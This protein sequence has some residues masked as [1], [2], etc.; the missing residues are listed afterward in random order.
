[1][2]PRSM[3][4]PLLLIAPLLVV[5]VAAV[6]LAVFSPEAPPRRA[7]AT[8]YDTG[9]LQGTVLWNGAPVSSSWLSCPSWGTVAIRKDGSP[10][11][12]SY[13]RV[14]AGGNYSFANIGVGTYVSTAYFCYHGQPGG[15]LGSGVATQVTAGGTSVED[16]DTTSTAG[17]ATGQITV[18]GAPA[19]GRVELRKAGSNIGD[20]YFSNGSFTWLLPPGTHSGNVYLDPNNTFV[21]TITFSI[22]AGETTDVGEVFATPTFT[23]TNTP[24]ITPTP[25]ITATPSITP[26]PTPT[27]THTPTPTGTTPAPAVYS[28]AGD[29]SP[30]SN[31]NAPWS[32]GLRPLGGSFILYDQRFNDNGLDEWRHSVIQS[33]GAPVVVHNGTD[34]AINGPVGHLIWL[35]GQLSMHPGSQGQQSV[36]RFTAPASGT[37]YVDVTFMVGDA[38]GPAGEGTTTTDVHVYKNVTNVG[39]NGY[40]L[41]GEALFNG[42][43]SG[44]VSATDSEHFSGMMTLAAGDTVDFVV[45]Y[46][47]GSFLYDTTFVDATVS[48]AAIVTLTPTITPTPSIT[49]TPTDT[50]T[51]TITPTPTDTQTPTITPTPTATQ[52]P[53]FVDGQPCTPTP[54]PR[55]LT[56]K[57]I[58]SSGPLNSIRIGE[59][60]SCQVGHSGD[61]DYE[62]YPPQ[63]VW[64]DCGTFLSADGSLYA[65]DFEAHGWTA[66][67]ALGRYTPFSS[68]SQSNVSGSGSSSD[69]FKVT[70]IADAGNNLRLTETDSY[71]R[72]QESYRTDV[73]ITNTGDA[74]TS[75]VLYRGGDCYLGNSDFGYGLVDPSRGMVAC[76]KQPNNEPPGRLMEWDPLTSGNNFLEEFYA[77]L[78][79]SIGQKTD[80]LDTCRGNDPSNPTD[81]ST[82]LDNSAAL[83]WRLTLQPGESKTLSHLT[84]FSDTGIR[85]LYVSKNVDHPLNWG[86]Q[87]GYSVSVSNPN[88]FAV[89]LLSI[90]D[91]LP[92]EFSYV[93]DSTTGGV[94]FNPTQNGSTLTW[95]GPFTLSGEGSIS[96]HLLVN[97]PSTPANYCNTARADAGDYT[98]V[99]S[100]VCLMPPTPP[101]V[102]PPPT[103]TP[104]PPTLTPTPKGSCGSHDDDLDGVPNGCDNCP[105]LYNPNQADSDGDGT[106]DVCEAAPA[107]PT[108]TLT[109]TL[110][111]TATR[112]WTATPT[113]TPTPTPT[114]TPT[115]GTPHPPG[116]GGS[117]LLPP[118]AIAAESSKNASQDSSGPFGAWVVLIGG[119][120]AAIAVALAGYHVRRYR[121]P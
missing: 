42:D 76:A 92:N 28:L 107:T 33:L 40:P 104:G 71:V 14:D 15:A 11:V 82:L 26:T 73:E 106:G 65:P 75:L 89:T 52:T 4:R 77:D 43:I 5:T 46:G 115:P 1:M 83:S 16:I 116:V 23:P 29:F 110:T 61:S 93:A 12:A 90:S 24:T 41:D 117:V 108:P 19:S 70:T 37:Y 3:M 113:R 100:T 66:T 54:T 63:R 56:M 21:G 18:N 67:R 114:R 81:C 101:P 112:T 32:Y 58:S 38:P 27:D 36:S 60:L 45:G 30:I 118:A 39:T 87:Q 88:D 49:P 95:T 103:N 55:P 8:D 102:T 31:P 94:N 13:S 59:D 111:P 53:C 22:T 96:F 34:H 105:T 120:A 20:G 121:L 17:V 48:N 78:W 35:P 119:L 6:F 74:A 2:R 9:A 109:P 97:L 44:Y 10:T 68:I 69:P 80:L 51:P 57:T 79:S 50:R 98:V 25:T 72:G 86:G 91:Q 47:N 84:T 99:S 62:F 64:G 85:P 7:G